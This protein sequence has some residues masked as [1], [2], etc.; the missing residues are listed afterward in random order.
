MTLKSIDF[1]IASLGKSYHG[2]T[3]GALALATDHLM[4]RSPMGWMSE[5]LI[6]WLLLGSTDYG[7]VFPNKH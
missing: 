6:F 2:Y 1:S 5:F 3:L 7:I 4:D